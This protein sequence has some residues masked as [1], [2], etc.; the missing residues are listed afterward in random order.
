VGETTRAWRSETEQGAAT[1][2][3]S[4]QPKSIADP[5]AVPQRETGHCSPRPG[6]AAGKPAQHQLPARQHTNRHRREGEWHGS[7]KGRPRG[8]NAIFFALRRIRLAGHRGRLD[9]I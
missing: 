1:P 9:L 2:P 3:C 6:D 4:T 5:R 8:P 7:K